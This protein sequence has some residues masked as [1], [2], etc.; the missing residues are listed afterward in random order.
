MLDDSLQELY[1][2][3]AYPYRKLEG[4]DIR[5]LRILPRTETDDIECL[6]HQIPIEE[7]GDFHSLSYVWGDVTDRCTITLENQPFEVTRSLFEA[8]DQLRECPP[9]FDSLE[10]YFWID[11][12]C[13]NQE[14][15]DERSQQVQRM[16]DIYNGSHTIIWLGPI[17]S[18]SA[19]GPSSCSPE[20]QMSSEEAFEFLFKKINSM[21]DEWEPVGENNK[22]VIN[23]CLGR[24]YKA[25]LDIM[26]EILHRPWFGRIWTLQEACLDSW[27]TVHLGPY[28][29]SLYRFLEFTEYFALR[30]RVLYLSPG[31]QRVLAIQ[32]MNELLATIRSSDGDGL[33]VGEVLTKILGI[34]G[35]AKS[36]DPRDQIYGLLSMLKYMRGGDL[37]DDLSPNYHM[38]YTETYWNYAAFLFQSTGDLHLLKCRRNELH[39]VPSWVPDFRYLSAG[40][41]IPDPSVYVT[42]DKKVLHLQGHILG[43]FRCVF[44][45]VD[46]EGMMPRRA[47]IPLELTNHLRAFEEQILKPSALAREITIEEAFNNMM[48]FATKILPVK[49]T[50]SSF[51]EVY[52]T[53]R[54]SI[55]T[56]RSRT[57]KKKRTRNIVFKEQTIVDHFTFHYL[58]LHDGTILVSTREDIEVKTGDLICIFKGSGKPGLLRACGENFIFLGMC[59]IRGGPLEKKLDDDFWATA[60]IQDI[61]LV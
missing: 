29:T 15:I 43:T 46:P 35:A 37:P 1:R 50:A 14:D 40:P 31:V 41:S 44:P 27:L 58:L 39:D 49:S 45:R 42:P 59:I 7:A 9:D 12:I 30:N 2:Q 53:L 26:T 56:R 18:L 54:D 11:A 13:I 17:V 5:L 10:E 32:N 61:K 36:T 25:V 28:S 23:R 51:Y 4:S 55:R 8:L 47:K 24:A 57:A 52:S 16:I 3:P 6:L 22:L 20:H 60:D 34:A 33:K 19:D 21:G 38:S 48:E